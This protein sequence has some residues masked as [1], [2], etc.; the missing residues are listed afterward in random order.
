MLCNVQQ[1]KMH[2]AISSVDRMTYLRPAGARLYITGAK[3]TAHVRGHKHSPEIG[4]DRKINPF[5]D[6]TK[7][8]IKIVPPSSQRAL[9]RITESFCIAVSRLHTSTQ[10]T[11]CQCRYVSEN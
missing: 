11:I 9:M 2:P 1:C 3:I 4:G 8:N 10:K 5:I 6:G 7:Y